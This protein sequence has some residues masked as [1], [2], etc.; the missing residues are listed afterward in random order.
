[1]D[2]PFLIGPT[3]ERGQFKL[4]YDAMI[5]DPLRN[6]IREGGYVPVL[7]TDESS[8]GK[9]HRL[10]LAFAGGREAE[11][12]FTGRLRWLHGSSTNTL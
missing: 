12:G 7:F 8:V 10:F 9:N 5:R 4:R 1:M 3:V 11:D 6:E 2:L